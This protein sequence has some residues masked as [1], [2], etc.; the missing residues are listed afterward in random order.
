MTQTIGQP[1]SL[2]FCCTSLLCFT[3][4]LFLIAPLSIRA[5][6]WPV[7]NCYT[8]WLQ[9]RNFFLAADGTQT[10]L[11]QYPF[12]I[13]N[14]ISGSILWSLIM[15]SVSLT[16]NNSINTKKM[17]AADYHV[18]FYLI[19]RREIFFWTQT[20]NLQNWWQNIVSGFINMSAISLIS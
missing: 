16:G 5:I 13:K 18:C 11:I 15:L 2:C 20:F 1:C 8:G 3:L 19:F 4:L 9:K 10:S 17:K 6:K 14:L 12:D 7:N